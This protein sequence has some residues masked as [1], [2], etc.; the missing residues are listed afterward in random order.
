MNS[1][2]LYY[3][4]TLRQTEKKNQNNKKLKAVQTDNFSYL[5]KAGHEV[6]S[7]SSEPS[8]LPKIKS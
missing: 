1:C 2:E 3:S 8:L 7:L 6:S 4:H 5:S